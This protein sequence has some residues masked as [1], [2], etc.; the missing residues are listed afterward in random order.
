MIR[1]TTVSLSVSLGNHNEISRW[2]HRCQLPTSAHTQ[3]TNIWIVIIRLL[4][5]VECVDKIWRRYKERRSYF[6]ESS[7]HVAFQIWL[8]NSNIS[9]CSS[10]ESYSQYLFIVAS[11]LEQKEEKTSSMP[12]LLHQNA[13]GSNYSVIDFMFSNEFWRFA[14]VL[15]NRIGGMKRASNRV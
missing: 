5:P 2:Q 15:S 7:S 14:S 4:S 6:N 10:R 9:S 1:C 12:D 11:L 13:K 3:G 8:C